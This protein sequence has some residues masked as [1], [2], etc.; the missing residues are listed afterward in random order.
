MLSWWMEDNSKELFSA[1]DS[2]SVCRLWVPELTVILVGLG[3]LGRKDL[4]LILVASTP[5]VIDGHD[6]G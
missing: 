5:A 1:P 4:Q 3:S 2:S 6:K